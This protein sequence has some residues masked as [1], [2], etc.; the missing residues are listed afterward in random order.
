[1]LKEILPL[2][3]GDPRYQLSPLWGVS[4]ESP[5]SGRSQAFQQDLYASI[6]EAAQTAWGAYLSELLV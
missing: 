3:S 2:I 4:E 6:S 1:M 5:V